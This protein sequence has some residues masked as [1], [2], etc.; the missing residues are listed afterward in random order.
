MSGLKKTDEKVDLGKLTRTVYKGARGAKYVKMDGEYVPLSQA[1]KSVEKKSGGG[2]KP[3]RKSRKGGGGVTILPAYEECSIRFLYNYGYY[4]TENEITA[5][6]K[7]EFLTLLPDGTI[8]NWDNG[9]LAFLPNELVNFEDHFKSMPS[10]T[11]EEV[12]KK[13]KE[14][15]DFNK[16]KI[17]ENRALTAYVFPQEAEE[18]L[19]NKLKSEKDKYPY[20]KVVITNVNPI[21]VMQTWPNLLNKSYY[22]DNQVIEI[23]K[24]EDG[25][26][27]YPE[28]L[29]PTIV[30]Q[31]EQIVNINAYDDFVSTINKIFN[32]EKPPQVQLGF[33]KNLKYTLR[34]KPVY[35]GKAEDLLKYVQDNKDSV[36]LFTKYN[37]TV[38]MSPKLS[39]QT[40][41]GSGTK[42][43]DMGEDNYALYEGFGCMVVT[44]LDQFKTG[45]RTTDNKEIVFS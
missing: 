32:L 17:M 10:S 13:I 37:L 25:K 9:K 7:F 5:N 15:K 1:K 35:I 11:Q 27:K 34:S 30:T 3:T 4:V 16:G 28:Y 24:G 14:N 8:E 2:K 18:K 6:K 42:Q 29:N 36:V 12:D 41:K 20:E 45:R 44:P 33:T 19:Q 22:K 43:Y 39:L 23:T 38:S 40:M 26:I 31:L 21:R